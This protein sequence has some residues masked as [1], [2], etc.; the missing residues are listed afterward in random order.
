[1]NDRSFVGAA[2]ATPSYAL[3]N[4]MDLYA[5]EEYQKAVRTVPYMSS[6]SWL[7]AI[8]GRF[9][10]R[11]VKRSEYSFYEEGQFMKAAATIAA[12]TPNGAKFDITL[13]GDNHMDIG[14]TDEAS[15]PVENMTVLF[16]DG[17]TTG[18]VESKD[19]TTPG[20]HV[21]TVKKLNAAQDIASVALVGTTMVFYSNAQPARSSQTQSRVP[22]FEKITN[23]F[24]IVREKFDTE[25]VELQNRLRFTTSSGQQYMWYKGIE[26]TTQRFEFQKE[27]AVLLTPQSESLTDKNAKGVQTAFGMLPQIDQH[28][29][30]L[31]YFN[32]PEGATFDEV[33]MALD[34]N[35]AEKSYIVGHGFNVMLKLKDWLVKFAQNGTGNISFS[36]FDGGESQ[37]IRLNFKSYSV[38][39][40]EFYFQ[41]WDI[42]SHKDSLGAPGLPFRHK[43]VF[44]PSGKTRNPDPDKPANAPD[45]E[46]YLQLV[47]PTWAYNPNIDKGDYLMWE[48]GALG[49]PNPTSD[50]LEK[51][52]HMA[53]YISLEMRC[54]HKFA[55]LDLA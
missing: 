41:Q 27:A 23:K 19:T 49:E 52:V 12:I 18:F 40:W 30:N 7:K 55:Q 26:D 17:K 6:L 9:S 1:M 47:S 2:A 20:A 22:Q 24:Q 38:G 15:F 14:G 11:K 16:Q 35:Y 21:V 37:A 13:H 29:I 54:R 43:M 48:T 36:P 44:I 25:D 32:T 3:F 10:K 8:K 46:P 31:E 42:F 53:A 50:V 34:N 51:I 5:D 28:G 39:A 33:M 45:Y 4:P